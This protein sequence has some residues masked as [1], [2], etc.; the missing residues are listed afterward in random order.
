MP[1]N[2]QEVLDMSESAAGHS[3]LKSHEISGDVVL[4]NIEEESAA[5]LEA[6]KAAGVGHAAKTLVKDGGLRSIMLGFRSGA[7]LKDHDAAG[8]VSIH[9]LSGRVAVSSP[10]R[11]D[12]LSAGAVIVFGPSVTHSLEASADSVVLLTI[13]WPAAK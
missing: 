8:P 10:G 9:V 7:T 4:L 11:S 2:D 6:A 5:I 13:A 12:S 3:Y 1:S